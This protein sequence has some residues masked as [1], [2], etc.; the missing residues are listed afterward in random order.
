MQSKT[1]T[2]INNKHKNHRSPVE[3]GCIFI[4]VRHQQQTGL[5]VV[6]RHNDGHAHGQTDEENRQDDLGQVVTEVSGMMEETLVKQ[7]Q[8]PCE[9]IRVFHNKR[10]FPN[11]L[12]RVSAINMGARRRTCNMVCMFQ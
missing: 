12:V 9:E 6:V 4:K 1:S 11:S 8:Y 5:V 3:G 10:Y 2:T 7:C